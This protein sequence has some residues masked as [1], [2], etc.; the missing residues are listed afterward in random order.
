MEVKFPF[1][2]EFVGLPGAGKTTICAHLDALRRHQQLDIVPCAAPYMGRFGTIHLPWIHRKRIGVARSIHCLFTKPHIIFLLLKFALMCRP[3]CV[4]RIR[5][6][7]TTIAFI[8]RLEAERSTPY[9]D[10]QIFVLEQGLIQMFSTIALPYNGH[11]PP[12]PS[13]LVQTIIPNRIDGLLWLD[14]S[15]E[16]ALSRIRNRTHGKSRIDLWI[17]DDAKD[18]MR[19]M[20][21]V[22]DQAVQAAKLLGVPVLRLESTRPAKENSA[23]VA[24][25]GNDFLG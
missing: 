7:L 10:E 13:R 14:C 15:L 11:T 19:A 4:E 20:K 24:K 17:N 12:D 5:N 25:W 21:M 18:S 9:P 2:V 6:T 1:I 3:L 23:I 16:L 22:I 8:Q